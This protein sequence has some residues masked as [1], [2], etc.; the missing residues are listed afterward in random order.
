PLSQ[1]PTQLGQLVV[2]EVGTHVHSQHHFVHVSHRPHSTDRSG[3]GSPSGRVPV[4]HRTN[5]RRRSRRHGSNR[6]VTSAGH[7]RRTRGA[8]HPKRSAKASSPSK[9]SFGAARRARGGHRGAG[10]PT[11]DG[12]L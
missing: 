4:H 3:R 11:G 5:S 9:E 6:P 12:L 8:D 7:P 1:V 2:A 10:G